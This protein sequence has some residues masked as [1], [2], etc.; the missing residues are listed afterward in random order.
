[1]KVTLIWMQK[2]KKIEFEEEILV[3]KYNFKFYSNLN[4][5]SYYLGGLING[6]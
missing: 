3:K 4:D 6:K 5:E 1:M 2:R